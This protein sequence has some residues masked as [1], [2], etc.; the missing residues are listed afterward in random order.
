M[1]EEFLGV[2]ARNH[3]VLHECPGEDEGE[4]DV[5]RP[6][7]MYAAV[8]AILAELKISSIRPHLPHV[9][10]KGGATHIIALYD[11]YSMDKIPPIE[12]VEKLAR[13]SGKEQEQPMWYFDVVR[14]KWT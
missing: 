9:V 13:F 2:C 4:F 7:T 11:N 5:L 12:D 10:K 14:W 3:G 1:K 6:D 8:K